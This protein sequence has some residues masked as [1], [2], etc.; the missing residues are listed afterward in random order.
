MKR[1]RGNRIH[2]QAERPGYCLSKSEWLLSSD[3]WPLS[4]AGLFSPT[5]VDSSELAPPKL[6]SIVPGT[7]SGGDNGSL[8]ANPG[9]ALYFWPQ[10]KSTSYACLRTVPP[11]LGIG[12]GSTSVA[13]FGRSRCLF[14]SEKNS[15]LNM[16]ASGEFSVESIIII[17]IW[18]GEVSRNHP[19]PD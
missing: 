14:L 4:K 2:R 9:C 17:I 15:F 18:N 10:E 3:V 12:Q 11:M 19:V 1:P 6:G 13:I 8:R 16:W 7:A 5:N